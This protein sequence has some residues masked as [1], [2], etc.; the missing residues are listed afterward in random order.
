MGEADGV[1]WVGW[2]LR[3]D[4]RNRGVSLWSWKREECSREREQEAQGV[5]ASRSE[6][7]SEAGWRG[8]GH[9]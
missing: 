7:R 5:S 9:E 1:L 8:G 6:G 4:L 2:S 3:S